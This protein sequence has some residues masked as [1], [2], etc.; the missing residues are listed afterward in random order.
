MNL[1]SIAYGERARIGMLLPSGNISAEAELAAMLPHDVAIHTTRLP[2]NGSRD[3]Q[4]LGMIDGV[5]AAACLLAH[6]MPSLIVF[7]CTA[8]STWNPEMDATLSRRIQAATGVRATT[9][10]D[11]IAAA[12][13]TL[14]ARKIVLI[15][16]YI[17][18][19]NE[20][21]VRFLSSLGVQVL[22]VCGLGLSTPQEM[23]AVS[24]GE[25]RD[26]SL[27]A[28]NDDADAYFI[29]CTAIRTL[30]VIAE[31]ERSL[32]RPVV[33]SNQIMGWH[34]IRSCGLN[35]RVDGVGT[36]FGV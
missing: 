1:N 27:A 14:S 33:T 13:R 24:P 23:Y 36:L 18:E 4:L 19:I 12:L 22:G 15:S 35:D 10:A 7:H 28:R 31:I 5:D 26:L 25:W 34:A 6:T 20:R 11:G 16:P 32:S 30:A 29:S 21:E 8:V 2:L 9:T 3:E 17:D